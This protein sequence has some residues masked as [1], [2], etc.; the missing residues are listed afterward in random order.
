PLLS[1]CF[2]QKPL[3]VVYAEESEGVLERTLGFW[4]LF[5]LGFGGT[6]G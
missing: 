4:D 1:R 2:K 3:Q 5:A 6:V